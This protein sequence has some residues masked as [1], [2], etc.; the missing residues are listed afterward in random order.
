MIKIKLGKKGDKFAIV[1]DEFAH[2]AKESWSFTKR[3]R[4][5]VIQRPT[6]QMVF[7][8]KALPPSCRYG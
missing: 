3:Q 4:L 6:V 8:L 1:D 5:C 2:L 7:E